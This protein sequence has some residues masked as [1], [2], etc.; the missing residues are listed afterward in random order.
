MTLS[1]EEKNIF[2]LLFCLIEV[3]VT[4]NILRVAGILQVIHI[5]FHTYYY[6]YVSIYGRIL[7][8]ESFPL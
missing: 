3:W 2:P 8:S 4:Y 1:E 7:S 6:M 5:Y